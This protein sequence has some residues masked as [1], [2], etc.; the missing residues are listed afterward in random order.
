MKR[1]LLVFIL[2]FFIAGSICWGQKDSSADYEKGRSLF[3]GICRQCHLDKSEGDQLTAYYLR[4]RPADFY[5]QDFWKR[6]DGKKIA[7]T[8]KSGKGPM[9]PQRLSE[10]DTQ[11]IIKYMEKK[12]KK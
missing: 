4:F 10:E 8:V 2:L 9:P 6:F 1:I 11:L 5:S 3:N 12:F 7:E